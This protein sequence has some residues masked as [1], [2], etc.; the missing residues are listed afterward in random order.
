MRSKE[1]RMQ[2]FLDNSS[3]WQ[4][5]K[6]KTTLQQIVAAGMYYLRDKNQVKCWYCNGGLL[7]WSHCDN[8]WVEHA[9]WFPSCE[10]ILERKGLNFVKKVLA[11]YP[12]LQRSPLSNL[13][14]FEFTS[15]SNI[16]FVQSIHN[17]QQVQEERSTQATYDIRSS[18][19]LTNA[20]PE[21]F[22]TNSCTQIA[23]KR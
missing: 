15:R 20:E 4:A 8:P 2:T 14:F 21:C 11:M 19:S 23:S 12:R 17:A 18:R 10:Y 9:K 6:I 22:E 13:S 3:I 16:P 1:S 5:R 7:N